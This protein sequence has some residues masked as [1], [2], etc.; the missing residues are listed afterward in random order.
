MY[1]D[2]GCQD[3]DIYSRVFHLGMMLI[4]NKWAFLVSGSIRKWVPFFQRWV[5][6]YRRKG[7]PIESWIMNMIDGTLR[8]MDAGGGV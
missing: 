5:E 1:K 2:F 7:V 3:D 8:R 6:A 4:F